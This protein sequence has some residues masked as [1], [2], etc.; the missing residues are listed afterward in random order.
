[1]FRRNIIKKFFLFFYICL[2]ILLF[3]YSITVYSSN[4][5]LN[6]LPNYN[7]DYFFSNNNFFWPVPG[8]HTITSQFGPRKS[9]TG[10]ASTN[11]SGIDISA[12]EG[13]QI[14]S[15]ISGK[16]TFVGFQGANGYTISIKNN[17]IEV[18]FCHVS[19][20]FMVSV[21]NIISQGSHIANVGPK[22]VESTPNNP[23]KD[24]T[25]KSTNGATTGSHLHL[26][27]KK[28][29]I[30]VNPLNFF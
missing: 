21:N 16:V 15:V 9:P 13:T 25:G 10:G 1:M 11:H 2:L 4:K 19:P 5:N 12:P 28:D 30:A 14:Y 8:Y 26:T 23:Y 29:G 24:S 18:L 3:F 27:I 20:N 22:Y 7:E 17:N 6:N